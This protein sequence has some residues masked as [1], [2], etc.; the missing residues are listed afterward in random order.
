MRFLFLNIFGET[1]SHMFMI[2]VTLTHPSYDNV[3]TNLVFP[4]CSPACAEW[5]S[6]QHL[7]GEL[8][9]ED[10]NPRGTHHLHF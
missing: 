5:C 4:V 7:G 6:H 2:S 9:G 8:S 10:H 3:A 1:R